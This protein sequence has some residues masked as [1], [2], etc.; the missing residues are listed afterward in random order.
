[1]KLVDYDVVK[2]FCVFLAIISCMQGDG[3]RARYMYMRAVEQIWVL[4]IV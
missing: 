1:M 2:Q 4:W 3:R